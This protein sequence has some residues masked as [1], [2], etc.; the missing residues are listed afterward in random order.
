VDEARSSLRNLYQFAER[1]YRA[2]ATQAAADPEAVQGMIALLRYLGEQQSPRVTICFAPPEGIEGGAID[3]FLRQETGSSKVHGVGPSFTAEQNR[4]REWR[5]V[6]A[7]QGAI[8]RV[9]GEDLFDL[10]V[11]E[12]GDEGPR[13]LVRYR[14]V[15]TGDFYTLREQGVLPLSERDVYAGIGLV[16]DFSTQVPG[17]EYPP[18][19]DPAQGY[20][21]RTEAWPAMNFD[22]SY[23]A[24][25]MSLGAPEE[26]VYSKM[27][28]TAFE[29]FTAELARA[30]GFEPS[31]GA[32]E[33]G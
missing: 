30:Y 25:S 7:M 11:G 17:S 18:N 21:F 6:Y 3:A 26:S 23:S 28:D 33:G 14:V 32:N 2:M 19:P 31:P 1:S 12:I 16:F 4:Q 5:V 10:E 24:A 13:F 27:V 9:L 8:R 22:V 20:R 29:R 15:G